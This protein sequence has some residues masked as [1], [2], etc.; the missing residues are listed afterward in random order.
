MDAD[1]FRGALL[2]LA[3]GDALGTSVEFQ[4]PGSFPPVTDIT[5]GGPFALPAGAWTDDT[6]MALCLGESLL[7]REGFDPVDQLERYVRWYRH[8]HWSSTG[9]CFDIG[10]ATRAALERFE[11]TGEPFPGDA[12]PEAA[13]NGPLMKLAPVA[14]AFAADPEVAIARAGESARTTHGAP[15]AVDAARWFAAVLVAELRGEPWEPWAPGDLHPEVAAVAAGSYVGREPPAIRGTG[16]V[17][18]ALEA[19]LWALHRTGSFEAGALAAVNLGDDADTTGAIFGQLAGARYGEAGIPERWRQ[20]LVRGNDIR[21]MADDLHALAGRLA[22]GAAAPPHRLGSRFRAA[23]VLAA[24]LHAGQLRKGT[25]I[26]YIGHLLAVAAT[27]IEDGGSE[28]EAIAALLHDA[29]EDQGGE[30]VLAAI[31][32]RFGDG[33]GGIVAEC[34]DTFESPKPPWRERKQAYVA[35]LATASDGAI[36]VSLAD[37]LHNA[38]AIVRDLSL[39]GPALWE[40]FSAGRE[41]QLWYY[42]ELAAAFE[43]RR[44]GVLT[45]ELRGLVDE[46]AAAPRA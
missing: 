26:P 11:R 31:R 39:S 34:S 10:G 23:L 33:V 24:E 30:Q 32:A 29:A 27:V 38:R 45:A 4:A 14:L 12:D 46:M 22:P 41:A 5:G 36:R 21:S 7:A 1:R 37:K 3:A 19:A 35:H 13:G 9:T 20:I 28:D 43:A 18:A 42:G 8:G 40:R 2:G 16:Y 6:S 44:P 17:V 25:D 15:Q